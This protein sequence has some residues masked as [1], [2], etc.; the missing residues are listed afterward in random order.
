ME[1]EFA[2]LNIYDFP[3][4]VFESLLDRRFFFLPG[5]LSIW[6]LKTCARMFVAKVVRRGLKSG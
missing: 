3:L 4:L 2:E 1:V 5:D 6:R